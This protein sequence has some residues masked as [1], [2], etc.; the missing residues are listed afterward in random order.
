[1]NTLIAKTKALKIRSFLR[2][3]NLDKKE[4]KKWIKL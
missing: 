1:M 4:F 2:F 3:Y